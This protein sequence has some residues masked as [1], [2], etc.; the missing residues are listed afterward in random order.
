MGPQGPQ[1]S[2]GVQGN[3]GPQGF[4]GP[5]G[6]VG[7]QGPQGDIGPQGD[8]GPQGLQGDVGSQGTLGP[9]G[10]QGVTGPSGIIY[11]ELLESASAI[12]EIYV[13][14]DSG[15]GVGFADPYIPAVPWAIS[16]DNV[17]SSLSRSVASDTSGNVY[18]VG[19]FSSDITFGTGLSTTTL[20]SSNSDTYIAKI[21]SD[22]NFVWVVQTIVSGSAFTNGY[23]ITADL[24]G[25]VYISGT[26]TTNVAIGTTTI[27]TGSGQTCVFV[28]KLNSSGVFQWAIKG[29]DSQTPTAVK[30]DTS[31]NVFI[32]GT[33]FNQGTFGTT[34]L[35]SAGNSD[36]FIA[37]LDTNGN[38]LWAVR[39]GGINV[40]KGYS[41]YTDNSNNCY[42][43]GE[44]NN[45]ADFGTTT[46]TSSGSFFFL[47]KLNSSGVWQWAISSGDPS[48]GRSVSV[49]GSGNSYVTG[50]F[51]GS[52]TI[53]TTTLTSAGVSDA[54]VAKYD[55]NG[56]AVW[57]V[58]MGGT[59]TDIGYSISVNSLGN[60]YLTGS[61]T[62]IATI[63]TT[64]LTST[65]SADIF[66]AKLDSNGNWL[67]SIKVGGFG[68]DSGQGIYANDDD[69][70]YVAGY[71]T[72]SATFGSGTNT[73]LLV[74]AP[75]TTN[76]FIA[77]YVFNSGPGMFVSI[78][79]V[80]S[81]GNTVSA[82]WTGEINTYS[83]LTPGALYYC[84]PP[85]KTI[86]TTQSP[87]FMGIA[88]SATNLVFNPN[89]K[90]II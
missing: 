47:A 88:T 2:V 62:G 17:L 78:Q 18:V 89:P 34:T 26:F 49:D 20:N 48:I 25:N 45:N 13:A 46:L 67:W 86:T 72:S 21:D 73:T 81:I 15:T 60:I 54:F 50:S 10:S 40:D 65:G 33:L 3:I 39:A 84:N 87:Y 82:L 14:V 16:P 28:A 51:T 6:L 29:P 53:G 61:F 42:V 35:T 37:K 59:N 71:F 80:G 76:S 5:Q 12:G 69:S 11:G 58:R 9:Q 43:T 74:S 23:G 68:D 4:V 85:S 36:I 24:A 83:G 32:T 52:M 90:Y 70:V 22:G 7:S 27:T 19:D 1:G 41:I 64:T 55:T 31:G 30:A 57:A 56:T 66:I 79:Q 8:V 75:G 44:H 77:K 63:G 38:W